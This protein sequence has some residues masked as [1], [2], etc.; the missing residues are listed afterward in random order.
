MPHFSWWEHE[1]LPAT[2]ESSDVADLLFLVVLPQ[3]QVI[4]SHTWEDEYSPRLKGTLCSFLSLSCI[5]FSIL[6]FV[7]FNYLGS[8][9]SDCYNLESVRLLTLG[10]PPHDTASS[11]PP[12]RMMEHL[13]WVGFFCYCI[14]LEYMYRY[15]YEYQGHKKRVLAL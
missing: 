14:N 12:G 8:F 6:C 1:S 2:C 13:S 3:P 9:T 7:N 5:L 4:S 10:P 11:L 15:K